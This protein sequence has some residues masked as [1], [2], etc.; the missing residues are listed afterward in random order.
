MVNISVISFE[1]Q[2]NRSVFKIFIGL[3]RKSE[4]KIPV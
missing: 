4:G 1:K 2:A 3:G